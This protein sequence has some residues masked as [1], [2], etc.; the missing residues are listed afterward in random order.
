MI[1][2]QT[3]KTC[4]E[5]AATPEAASQ[6][7]GN[8]TTPPSLA[9]VPTNVLPPTPQS[10]ATS[11]TKCSWP[12]SPPTSP[13]RPD[14]NR[15]RSATRRTSRPGNNTLP[16]PPPPPRPP[17][18]PPTQSPTAPL[19]LLLRLRL[20]PASRPRQVTSPTLPPS[21]CTTLSRNRAPVAATLRCGIPSA[22]RPSCT[23]RRG[24]KTSR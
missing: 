6:I 17:T 13:P 5:V 10:H 9:P 2:D 19:P 14:P 16:S 11:G 3:G 1:R 8:A 23:K 24:A 4:F 15:L 22:A 20:T 7:S 12:T 18:P 21:G